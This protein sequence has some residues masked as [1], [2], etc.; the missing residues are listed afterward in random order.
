MRLAPAAH[1]LRSDAAKVLLGRVGTGADEQPRDLLVV[2]VHRGVERRPAERGLG[3]VARAGLHQL[4]TDIG[5][6]FDVHRS[7]VER[8]VALLG[9]D[10]DVGAGLD[11]HAHHLGAAARG[12][13]V[14]R[15]PPR[16]CARGEGQKIKATEPGSREAAGKEKGVGEGRASHLAAVVDIGAGLDLVLHLE[17]VAPAGRLPQPPG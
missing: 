16:L 14:E 15:R 10:V 8:G 3:A 6:V 12:G 2:G 9:G 1:I 5:A 7:Q 13:V 17:H 4:H 11:E